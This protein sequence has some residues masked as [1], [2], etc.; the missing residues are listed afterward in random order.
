M[1]SFQVYVRK[2]GDITKN[3]MLLNVNFEIF[4]FIN[5][6]EKEESSLLPSPEP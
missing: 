3:L 4:E 1:D 6:C 5:K 2:L